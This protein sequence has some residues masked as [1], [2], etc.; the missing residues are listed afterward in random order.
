VILDVPG[1]DQHILVGMSWAVGLGKFKLSKV[2]TLAPR[3]VLVNNLPRKVGFREH[4]GEPPSN[5]NLEPEAQTSLLLM[6]P[7]D[8]KL[9]TITYP[10]LNARWCVI[11]PRSLYSKL[12]GLHQVC[13]SINT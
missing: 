10:G 7:R 13:T 8:E 4:G 11:R 6:R 9:I 1:K 3:F 2:V 5:S 12:M